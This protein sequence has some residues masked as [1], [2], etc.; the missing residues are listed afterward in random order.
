MTK[1]RPTPLLWLAPALML[2]GPAAAQS[3]MATDLVEAQRTELRA[4]MRPGCA[5]SGND[6]DIVVCARRD[7]D[8]YRVPA[9]PVA[10]GSSRAERAGGAQLAAMAAN[11]ADRCSPVGRH[12]QCGHVD[13]LGMGLMIV[14]EVIAGIE[15]RRD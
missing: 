11:D 6:A 5:P 14:R 10:E 9:G 8:R 1:S 3:D 4:T 12:Q 2:A 13:F 7:D 15:R